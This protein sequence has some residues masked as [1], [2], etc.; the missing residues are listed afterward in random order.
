MLF[1]NHH[2]LCIY[3]IE[4]ANQIN[5]LLSSQKC[6][7]LLAVM[8]PSCTQ[9]SETRTSR[10]LDTRWRQRLGEWCGENVVVAVVEGVECRCII[11]AALLCD[12]W[13]QHYRWSVKVIVGMMT[14]G[15]PLLLLYLILET[16]HDFVMHVVRSEDRKVYDVV[17]IERNLCFPLSWSA[18]FHISM[19][20]TLFVLYFIFPAFSLNLCGS[21]IV[22]RIICIL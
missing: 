2:I 7:K 19:H 4:R 9:M 15:L 14:W 6:F 20:D 13:M 22:F 8:A 1:C 10:L 12:V 11:I 18:N 5:Y 17:L 3:H 16:C 21:L